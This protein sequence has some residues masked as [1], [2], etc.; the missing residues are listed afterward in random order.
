[1]S[2]QTGRDS[3]AEGQQ[4]LANSF[5]NPLATLQKRNLMTQKSLN[6]NDSLKLSVEVEDDEE[7]DEE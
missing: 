2:D 3:Q 7:E 1:M 5:D 6:N 4:E